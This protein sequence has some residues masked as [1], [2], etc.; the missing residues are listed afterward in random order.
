MMPEYKAKRKTFFF[1]LPL[2]EFG[3][4]RE[5]GSSSESKMQSYLDA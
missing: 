3:S 2:L 5:P 1:P 4:M